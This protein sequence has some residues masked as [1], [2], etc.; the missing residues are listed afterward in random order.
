MGGGFSLVSA[1]RRPLS[2]DYFRSPGPS[3][4]TSA[5]G[6]RVLVLTLGLVDTSAEPEE[7]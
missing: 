1:S 2:V 5:G 3:G 4:F 7:I 6:G